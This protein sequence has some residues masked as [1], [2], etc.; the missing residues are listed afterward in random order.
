[1][2]HCRKCKTE[3]EATEFYPAKAK[4]DGLMAICKECHKG[5]MRAWWDQH[6]DKVRSVREFSNTKYRTKKQRIEQ[7]MNRQK[8]EADASS[9]D[10][11]TNA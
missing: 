6:Y 4:Q 11:N 7:K 8:Q 3:K 5:Y 9:A 1:M 2:R 10:A